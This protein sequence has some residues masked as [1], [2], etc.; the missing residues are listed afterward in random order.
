MALEGIVDPPDQHGQSGSMSLKHKHAPRWQPR[1]QESTQPYMV[2][3][4]NYTNT[5]P[6]YGRVTD[7]L[8]LLNGVL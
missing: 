5:D 7:S 2:T 3:G 4:A 1:P 8:L 6:V